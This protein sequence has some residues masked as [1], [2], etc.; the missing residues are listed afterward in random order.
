MRTGGV[1]DTSGSSLLSV[2][3]Q[4]VRRDADHDEGGAP[5]LL[6]VCCVELT[7]QLSGLVA[8]LRRYAAESGIPHLFFGGQT[9]FAAQLVSAELPRL[10]LS[11]VR[12]A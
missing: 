10:R 8:E 5:R 2:S 7:S 11:P 1:D 6:M 3:S 4:E 12:V 9:S